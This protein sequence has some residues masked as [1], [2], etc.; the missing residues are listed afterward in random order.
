MKPT[1]TYLSAS[2]SDHTITS[3]YAEE[4]PVV[5][6]GESLVK[7]GRKTPSTFVSMAMHAGHSAAMLRS[8]RTGE[9]E[10]KD[11]SFGRSVT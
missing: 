1:E 9:K 5:V 4:Q 3:Y 6:A 8:C 7:R 11:F 2:A 10:L